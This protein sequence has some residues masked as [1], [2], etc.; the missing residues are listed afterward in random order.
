MLIS[1]V[2]TLSR[3]SWPVLSQNQVS[4]TFTSL[5]GWLIQSRFCVKCWLAFLFAGQCI[6]LISYRKFLCSRRLFGNATHEMFCLIM[7]CL[8]HVSSIFIAVSR[9]SYSQP[10]SYGISGDV[11]ADK[12]FTMQSVLQTKTSSVKKSHVPGINVCLCVDRVFFV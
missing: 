6:S 3:Q 2:V 4:V 12:T 1:V 9:F 5:P 8:N 10:H 7:N 11:N